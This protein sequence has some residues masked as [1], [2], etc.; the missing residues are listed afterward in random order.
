MRSPTS[1]DR[2]A[3]FSSKPRRPQRAANFHFTPAKLCLAV[4]LVSRAIAQSAP[5]SWNRPWHCSEE[6][7]IAHYAMAEQRRRFDLNT[8]K[9]YSLAELIDLAESYNPETRVARERAASDSISV[10]ETRVLLRIQS[11]LPAVFKAEGQTISIEL[12]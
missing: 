6:Q 5:V 4:L 8:V 9:L 1:A 10:I 12:F 11:E 7:E 2:S 3:L